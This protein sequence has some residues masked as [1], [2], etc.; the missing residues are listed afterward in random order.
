MISIHKGNLN[1]K[2]CL[3]SAVA[4]TISS[5]KANELASLNKHLDYARNKYL[6][7]E[8]QQS[9]KNEI[10]INLSKEKHALRDQF[11]YISNAIQ[12]C[13]QQL[14]E[15]RNEPV[16]NVST[17]EQLKSIIICCGQ[18][19]ADNCKEHER[20]IRLQQKNR[21][22][23]TK[24]I[25]MENNLEAARDELRNLRTCLKPYKEKSD[26]LSRSR[27]GI[28]TVYSEYK[29]GALQKNFTKLTM[30][31]VE[32]TKCSSL[33][34]I[35]ELDLKTHLKTVKNLLNENDSLI[36][37]LKCLSRLINVDETSSSSA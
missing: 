10:I 14:Q 4:K 17:L 30:T 8:K 28:G 16:Q 5:A 2:T 29:L 3:I 36:N 37:D 23:T 22:L 19:H 32:L 6:D 27:P 34:N 15:I 7:L 11:E 9:E 20:C 21:F 12:L 13:Y 35:R 33:A 25:I 26:A 31:K 1:L 24:M 18:Y